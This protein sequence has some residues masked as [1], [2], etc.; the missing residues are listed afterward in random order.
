[1]CYFILPLHDI[2]YHNFKEYIHENKYKL[3]SGSTSIFNAMNSCD[4]IYNMDPFLADW[5]DNRNIDDFSHAIS[6][7]YRVIPKTDSSTIVV[8]CMPEK[9]RCDRFGHENIENILV[10]YL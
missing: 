8:F 2:I 7:I 1:M 4:H 6:W 10:R 5:F 3:N 9:S